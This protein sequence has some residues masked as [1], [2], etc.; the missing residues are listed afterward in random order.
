MDGA[1]SA[2]PNPGAQEVCF[3]RGNILKQR[4]CEPKLWIYQYGN[5]TDRERN[6]FY[7]FTEVG[8]LKEDFEV[9][10][11]WT[12]AKTLHRWTVLAFRFLRGR[13]N[14]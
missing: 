1:A 8:F 7:S 14:A 9:K 5:G 3:V 12:S 4:L 2:V 13:D 6:P 10:N 11:W